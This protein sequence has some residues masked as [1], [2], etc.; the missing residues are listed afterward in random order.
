M[1]RWSKLQ[2][3]LYTIIDPTIKFQIQCR[4]YAMDSECGST[5]LPRYWIT[6][7]REV[8][9]DY[10][11]Q[12]VDTSHPQRV[13]PTCYPYDTDIS[14]ISELIREYI[15]T[16]RNQ[17]LSKHFENDHWGLI[18]IL[19]AADSRVGSRQWPRL[20]K[21][22]HN[23]AALTVLERRMSRKAFG[24]S[25]PGAYKSERT[26]IHGLNLNGQE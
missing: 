8:I 15:D 16:P 26:K 23:A 20:M 18:N 24:I 2:R 10:P 11:R 25:D 6:L 13:H 19:R 1:K 12:F 9:W 5:G 17:L 22:T 14:A 7:G 4:I 3:Q 21:K